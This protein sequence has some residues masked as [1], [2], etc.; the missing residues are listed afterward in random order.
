MRRLFIPGYYCGFSNNKMSLEIAVALAHLTDRV[1]V[2]F[3]FRL[4]RRLPAEPGAILEPLQILDLFEIP[5]QYSDES[6]LK[7]WISAPTAIVCPWKPVFESVCT[8]PG[9]TIPDGEDFRAFRNGRLHVNAFT[10]EQH[11]ADDVYL[12]THTL[13]FYSYFFYLDQARRRDL[14]DLMRRMQPKPAYREAADR[15]VA[16]LGT[17]NAIHIRRGDFVDNALARDGYSRAG[18]VSG[19]E[20]AANLERCMRR[21]EL[22]VVCSD[23]GPQDEIFGALRRT[24]RNVV[25]LDEHL[26]RNPTVRDVFAGLPRDDE[27][28][29]VLLTQLVASRARVFAGTMFSTFTA[30]IH[31]ERG[32]AG[33]DDFLFCYDDFHSPMVR[34]DGCAFRPVDDGPYSWNRLRYPFSPDAYGWAREWPESFGGALPPVGPELDAGGAS[35]LALD[36][37]MLGGAATRSNDHTGACVIDRW[38]HPDAVV[39]WDLERPTAGTWGVEIRYGCLRPC[40]G[41]RYRVGVDGDEPLHARAW[42]T[43]HG[44]TVTPWMPLGRVR[45]PAGR[46]TLAI[47]G[48]EAVDHGVVTLHGLRLTPVAD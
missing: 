37:A 7:T 31:R 13:G 26:R 47:R 12:D 25:F 4:P 27:A 22:L 42:S 34:F 30:L 21:D 29:H 2:P 23:G 33:Q 3:R 38:T 39:S 28:V 24:F 36:A 41:S 40:A 11:A 43:T 19:A 45:L 14:V 46:S 32:F 15:I 9:T 6:V 44:S 48:L 5:V 8:L 1:L 20:I 35:P 16:T 10:A 17:F 18:A